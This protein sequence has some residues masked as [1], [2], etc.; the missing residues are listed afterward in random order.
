[1]D[2]TCDYHSVGGDHKPPS[3]REGKPA[4]LRESMRINKINPDKQNIRVKFL[5][6]ETI[7]IGENEGVAHFLVTIP[8]DYRIELID[9]ADRDFRSVSTW[10]EMILSKF[11]GV[12][13]RS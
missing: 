7:E 8:R 4:N 9:V 13:R 5:L 1:M 10:M 2:S 6:G 3:R 11:C 12:K